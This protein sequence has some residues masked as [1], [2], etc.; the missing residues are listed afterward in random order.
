MLTQSGGALADSFLSI[1]KTGVAE[2]AG[3]LVFVCTMRSCAGVSSDQPEASSLISTSHPHK[4]D[5]LNG[6]AHH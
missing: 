2:K 5:A 6:P 4:H 1:D 3:G